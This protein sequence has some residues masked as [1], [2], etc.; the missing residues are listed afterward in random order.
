M[1]LAQF[2]SP[3]LAT[4]PAIGVVG[5]IAIACVASMLA[6]LAW[7]LRRAIATMDRM[8]L[9]LE[10]LSHFVGLISAMDKRFDNIEDRLGQ[11]L[12]LAQENVETARLWRST[13]ARDRQMRQ[14]APP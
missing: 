12:T 9:T 2:P 6:M 3:D 5:W 13:E 14:Q 8:A 1:L 11:L 7:F 10:Q 4:D